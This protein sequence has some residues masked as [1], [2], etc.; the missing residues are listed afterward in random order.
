MTTRF[1][2]AP[3]VL[4]LAACQ[5][6]TSADGQATPVALDTDGQQFSYSA[7]Y[8]IGQRLSTMG[9]VEIDSAAMAAGLD[10]ALAEAEP[11]L[12]AEEMNAVKTRV[13]QAAA[14][15]R[16]AEVAEQAQAS[17]Q[18]GI[19]FLAENKTKEGV[20]VTESGLQY[21]ITEEGEGTSPTATDTVTVHYKGTLLDGTEFDSSYKRDQPA[22][23]RL[24]GV[25]PG[26]TEG[27]Q[28]MKPGGKATLFIP[29]ELAYGERGAGNL[30]GPN[31]TLIFEVELLSVEPAAA[32]G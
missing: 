17:T 22:K 21:L 6:N 10:D 7:G 27:L 25:I 18:R 26:W 3:A 19:D 32:E 31:E 9:E 2:W 24:N 14:E 16:N 15:K 13:Y 29:P 5:P 4:L 8:E 30:I 28:L 20:M 23:F 1:L 12:S 11:R